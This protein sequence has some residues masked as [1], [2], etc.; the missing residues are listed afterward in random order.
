MNISNSLR[1]E[2]MPEMVYTICKLA[3]S[4]TYDKETLKR[5]ITL[6]SSSK[7]SNELFNKVYRF[8]LDCKFLIDKTDDKVYVNFD[9]KELESFRLFRYKIFRNVFTNLSTVFPEIAM[10]Y[11]SQD[12]DVFA[13]K[14][15]VEL[16]TII[17]QEMGVT[18]EEYLLGFR[19]WMVALGLASL[20][21][22]GQSLT[23]VFA[24]HH[25]LM[26]W[27]EI[28]NPFKKKST[29]RARDFFSKLIE[30]CPIFNSCVSGNNINLALSMG[31][32]VLHLNGMIELKYITDS[33][34][35]WHLTNSISYPNTN[36][37]TEI[38]VR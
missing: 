34:D 13:K 10:W 29:I 23:F 27:L 26:D 25:I 36:N 2:C 18:S 32:R 22:S 7:E 28:S 4:K 35:I 8:A 17:P 37:I 1:Q 16:L 12:T 11:L 3:E 15:V 24:T 31:L 30:V 38:I 14:S 6:D 9:S 21:K 19:F 33:G 5:L 20:Q